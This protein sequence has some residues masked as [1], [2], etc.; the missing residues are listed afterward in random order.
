[1][2]RLVPVST[3]TTALQQ[4]SLGLLPPGCPGVIWVPVC[5]QEGFSVAPALGGMFWDWC[6]TRV[7][8]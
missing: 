2:P 7:N 8:F 1:M 3:P 5:T 6:W 4:Q